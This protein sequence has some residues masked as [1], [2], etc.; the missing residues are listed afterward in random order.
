MSDCPICANKY[1]N[2]VRKQIVCFNC[3]YSVCKECLQTYC[4]SK[5]EPQCINCH[6]IY[7]QDNCLQLFGKSITLKLDKNKAESIF[8]QELSLI[9][10]TIKKINLEKRK[11]EYKS[12]ESQIQSLNFDLEKQQREINRLEK[13]KTI[14][15][16]LCG[17]STCPDDIRDEQ[18]NISITLLSEINKTDTTNLIRKQT[19]ENEYNITQYIL[20]VKN[21]PEYLKRSNKKIVEKCNEKLIEKQKYHE[22]ISMAYTKLLS[23]LDEFKDLNEEF[24]P[25]LKCINKDCKGYLD[26]YYKCMLCECK[27]CK[28]CREESKPLHKCDP[29]LIKTIKEI[30]KESRP[31]PNCN[32]RI[33]KQSGCNQMFCIN[34]NTAF[35]WETGDI[36]KGRIHNPHY[37]EWIEKQK[38]K[39]EEKKEE[40]KKEEMVEELDCMNTNALIS[41]CYK[42]SINSKLDKDIQKL[43]N[44]CISYIRL[45]IH[46]M[47]VYNITDLQQNPITRFESY[48]KQ[49]IN[50]II[51]EQKWKTNLYKAYRKY[52][53]DSKLTLLNNCLFTVITDN[54]KSIVSN[55]KLNKNIILEKYNECITFINYYNTY[56]L[57]LS[58]YYN[59]KQFLY[60]NKD[61]GI[62]EWKGCTNSEI[63][64]QEK[65]KTVFNDLRVADWMTSIEKE[66]CEKGIKYINDI[67]IDKTIQS[68][69]NC[70][71]FINDCSKNLSKIKARKERVEYLQ[72]FKN[73]Y[74]KQ[75]IYK[76]FKNINYESTITHTFSTGE[77]IIAPHFFWL[78]ILSVNS[79]KTNKNKYDCIDWPDVTYIKNGISYIIKFKDSLILGLKFIKEEN[80]K[81]Y[82]I[83]LQEYLFYYKISKFVYDELETVIEKIKNTEYNYYLLCFTR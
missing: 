2:K 43:F 1:T 31:C 6:Q 8:Q 67:K 44:F 16:I 81:K 7:D 10:D 78:F 35:N 26:L 42:L 73:E 9:P 17:L 76:I 74:M 79:L 58:L 23:M 59:Y 83:Q 15:S 80:Y 13:D 48:R 52:E 21:P 5:V 24:M 51:N 50:N 66:W 69:E 61:K 25:Y 33:S 64:D 77:T 68:L 55:L 75:H 47:E 82:L 65:I 54:C 40:E 70:I 60:L 57:K 45:S 19:L 18:L 28:D 29:N 49:Y 30:E 14:A 56:S 27:V 22:N 20:G 62:E 4:L 38:K 71:S 46:V 72:L 37:F 11:K 36:E 63:I 32:I 12:L 39:E 3:K 41:I 53:Y 34:C